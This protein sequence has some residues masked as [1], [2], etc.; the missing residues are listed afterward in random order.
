MRKS[1][2]LAIITPPIKIKKHTHA[3]DIHTEY[4]SGDIIIICEGCKG[5]YYFDTCSAEETLEYKYWLNMF[6]AENEV[7]LE[8]IDRTTSR[9]WNYTTEVKL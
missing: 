2:P 3:Y 1:I 8:L 4:E 6:L 5:I 7:V 9:V